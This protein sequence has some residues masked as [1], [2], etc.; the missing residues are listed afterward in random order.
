MGY[1]FSDNSGEV[2]IMT[3]ILGMGLSLGAGLLMD[4]IRLRTLNRR[5]LRRQ[6]YTLSEMYAE[7]LA[8]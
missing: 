3:I 4:F 7:E 8:L 5:R 6:P 2:T 1:F